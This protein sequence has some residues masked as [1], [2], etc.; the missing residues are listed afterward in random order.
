MTNEFEEMEESVEDELPQ[1]SGEE[2][3]DLISSGA[4]GVPYDYMSAPERTKAPPRQD[5]GGKEVTITKA[6]ILLP[7]SNLEW[8][9]TRDKKKEQKRCQFILTYSDGKEVQ[10]EYYS[11]VR[12]FKRPDGKYSHPSITRDGVNQASALMATY[13]KYKEKTINEVSLREFLSF[14]NSQPK[15]VIKSV[16]YENPETKDKVKKNIVEKFL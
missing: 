7:P 8:D 5:W 10:M 11:G 2:G 3:E 12:V 13:S 4:S 6:E 15:A 1:E 14:L 16:E 9:K